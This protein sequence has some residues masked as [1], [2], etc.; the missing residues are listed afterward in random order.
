MPSLA[1]MVKE[2]LKKEV[3]ISEIDEPAIFSVSTEPDIKKST[4]RAQ[5]NLSKIPFNA[6]IELNSIKTIYANRFGSSTN[7]RKAEMVEE[8]KKSWS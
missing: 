3:E 5:K 1:D 2:R 6:S 8:I 7:K 4:Q